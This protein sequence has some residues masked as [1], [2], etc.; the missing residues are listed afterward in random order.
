MQGEDN[1]SITFW[2]NDISGDSL[3]PLSGLD[4]LVA[5]LF[6]EGPEI[7]A[8]SYIRVINCQRYWKCGNWGE[9]RQ[10][11]LKRRHYW[12]YLKALTFGPLGPGLPCL[13]CG[14]CGPW[15]KDNM[16]HQS[17]NLPCSHSV[18]WN[19]M[20]IAPLHTTTINVRHLHMV[21]YKG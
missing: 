14:P 5:H 9:Q 19:C 11:K 10:S 16:S 12:A 21:L 3:V 6:Q 8:F 15:K 7:K 20:C 18:L 2:T 13:P 4:G 17:A 1:V